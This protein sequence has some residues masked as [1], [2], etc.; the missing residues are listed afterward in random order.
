MLQFT[1]DPFDIFRSDPIVAVL[2]LVWNSWFMI[3]EQPRE[4]DAKIS[5][6]LI[7]QAIGYSGLDGLKVRSHEAHGFGSTGQPAYRLK[8][9]VRVSYSCQVSSHETLNAC[10]SDQ[11]T[12]TSAWLL[13]LHPIFG[14]PDVRV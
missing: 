13:G 2:N 5:R 9:G 6:L 4:V 7:V 1:R 11:E 14:V 8:R 3:V 10:H 12:S